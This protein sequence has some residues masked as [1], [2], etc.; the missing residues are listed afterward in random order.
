[1]LHKKR[2]GNDLASLVLERIVHHLYLGQDLHCIQRLPGG[3]RGS[4]AGHTQIFCLIISKKSLAFFEFFDKISWQSDG[5][6]STEILAQ[7]ASPITNQHFIC[8]H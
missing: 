4:H 8:I 3:V 5:P 1:M 6:S 7:R 2:S